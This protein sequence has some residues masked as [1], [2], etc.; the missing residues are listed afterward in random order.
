MREFGLAFTSLVVVRTWDYLE[1]T[2]THTKD[3]NRSRAWRADLGA[4]IRF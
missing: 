4:M 1:G 2:N 3:V